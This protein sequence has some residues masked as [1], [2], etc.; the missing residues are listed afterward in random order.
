MLKKIIVNDWGY[1]LIVV[2]LVLLG[3][4]TT[5][6]QSTNLSGSK[7]VSPEV[8]ILR[9]IEEARLSNKRPFPTCPPCTNCPPC[10]FGSPR[11]CCETYLAKISNNRNNGLGLHTPMP[12]GVL[13]KRIMMTFLY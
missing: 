2:L 9:I 13:S 11:V 1:L 12:P 8:R 10:G 5:F 6:G 7:I 3:S 4:Y